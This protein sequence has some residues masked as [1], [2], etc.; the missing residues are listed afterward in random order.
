MYNKISITHLFVVVWYQR[1]SIVG[2]DFEEQK[3]RAV[4]AFPNTAK[5]LTIEEFMRE[6]SKNPTLI[7]DVVFNGT[8]ANYVDYTEC[9]A[10]LNMLPQLRRVALV[11][12]Q[13]MR[14]ILHPRILFGITDL[15]ITGCNCFSLPG[16]L[17]SLGGRLKSLD[18]S[19]NFLSEL[20]LQAGHSTANLTKLFLHKNRFATAPAVICQMRELRHLDLSANS[21]TN[22]ESLLALRKLISL[23]VSMNT[24]LKVIPNE[25]IGIPT[26]TILSVADSRSLISPPYSI[27]KNGVQAMKSYLSTRSKT[28]GWLSRRPKTVV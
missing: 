21:L 1:S 2:S 16:F 13:V 15:A 3:W 25:V 12:T 27:A 26:L 6:C 22:L 18:L 9:V 28:A 24:E 17:W 19:N 11:N 10:L 7:N 23:N 4:A 5:L 20:P 8:F 14:F